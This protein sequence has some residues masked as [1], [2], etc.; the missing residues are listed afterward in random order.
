M[1]MT[2]Y[3]STASPWDSH[4]LALTEQKIILIAQ[5]ADLPFKER[6]SSHNVPHSTSTPPLS[7][8]RGGV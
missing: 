1:V 6:Q 5:T 2:H 4:V 8:L 7:L 3:C